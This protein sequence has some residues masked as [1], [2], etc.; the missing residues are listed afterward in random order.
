MCVRGRNV[1]VY[2]CLIEL[3]A[4]QTAKMYAL[5]STANYKLVP[6]NLNSR[7]P[8]PPHAHFGPRRADLVAQAPAPRCFQHAPRLLG[9]A[10]HAPRCL[11][12]GRTG[13]GLISDRGG[14]WSSVCLLHITG[15][16][17]TAQEVH[18]ELAT[19]PAEKC[20]FY[21]RWMAVYPLK[22]RAGKPASATS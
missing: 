11:L 9:D 13:V 14:P 4:G 2:A 22:R 16:P 12:P 8:C 18:M 17:G 15:A 10:E 5:L 21:V 7:P 3:C 20:S 19:A 6:L 1:H